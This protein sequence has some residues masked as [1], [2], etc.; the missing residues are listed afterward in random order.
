MS[1]TTFFVGCPVLFKVSPNG[2]IRAAP[3]ITQRELAH[4]ESLP[5]YLFNYYVIFVICGGR[6]NMHVPFFSRV[7]FYH[8]LSSLIYGLS[9]TR[10]CEETRSL[11]PRM[12]TRLLL[13]TCVCFENSLQ[14]ALA[15]AMTVAVRTHLTKLHAR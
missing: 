5:L 1:R 8:Q 7:L 9:Q 3:K 15:R 11:N 6:T 4:R 2:A 13:L 12:H 10:S 14:F